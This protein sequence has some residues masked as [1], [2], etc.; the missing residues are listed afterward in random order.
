MGFCPILANKLSYLFVGLKSFYTFLV[1]QW[2]Q[3]Q[4]YI[5]YQLIF[6]NNVNV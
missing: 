4:R 2:T 3:A 5:T 1:G 6:Y